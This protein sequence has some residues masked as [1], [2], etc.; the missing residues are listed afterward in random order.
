MTVVEGTEEFR[1]WFSALGERDI[2]VVNRVVA[3][4]A[5][6]GVTLGEP[7]S[8]A[9]RGSKFAL[10]EL[11]PKRGKSP[12]RIIYA[13]DPIRSA[14]LLLGGDKGADARFYPRA[15]EHAEALWLEHLEKVRKEDGS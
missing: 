8:S 6:Y 13:F 12:L 15:I 4:L 2:R 10:R 5:M 9:I 14:V 11:R 1:S 7:H 3:M